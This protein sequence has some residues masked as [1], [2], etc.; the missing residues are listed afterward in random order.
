MGR[1]V[2][3]IA[4]SDSYV[5]VEFENAACNETIRSAEFFSLFTD[6][7]ERVPVRTKTF[8]GSRVV[9]SYPRV[10]STN[11]TLSH[12]LIGPFAS[13]QV[14]ASLIPFTDSFV[15]RR[16]IFDSTSYFVSVQLAG[17]WELDAG[18]SSTP[19]ICTARSA[20]RLGNASLIELVLLS[21]DEADLPSCTIIINYTSVYTLSK[22]FVAFALSR[23]DLPVMI[24]DPSNLF[25]DFP[26][27]IAFIVLSIY[28]FPVIYLLIFA[29]GVK[30]K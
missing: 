30:V 23:C 27:W 21:G 12:E 17:Q 7:G 10:N 20:T 14:T 6:R 16:N 9:L 11:A 25:T 26:V 5:S 28:T 3:A 2:S 13:V 24:A 1:I 19:A 4:V 15:C 29:I 8:G 18:Y 22:D